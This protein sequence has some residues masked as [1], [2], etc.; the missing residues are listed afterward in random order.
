MPFSPG[1]G[2]LPLGLLAHA[3]LGC[4]C[5]TNVNDGGTVVQGG[6]MGEKEDITLSGSGGAKVA[7]TILLASSI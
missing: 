3:R 2:R 4:F 1:I 5:E 7:N 6:S